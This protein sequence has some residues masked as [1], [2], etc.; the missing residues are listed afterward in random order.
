GDDTVQLQSA[1]FHG[2]TVAIAVPAILFGG[3]GNDKLD[4]SGSLAN[5]VLLGGAGNDSLAGGSGR[6]LL[7]GGLGSD[8]LHG[9]GGDDILIG[10]TTSFDDNLSALSAI[11][12][13]WGRTDLAYQN[14]IN[15]LNG[16]VPGG[17]NGAIDLNSATVL[18][19]AAIDQL[20]GDSG[21]DWF[22]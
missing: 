13:E 14:R 1:R 20:W 22:L 11:M 15:H 17:L 8:R 6:D 9:G 2:T 12:A 5:S 21:Q 4:A 10:G 18:D 3:D 7:I 16:T 19:D